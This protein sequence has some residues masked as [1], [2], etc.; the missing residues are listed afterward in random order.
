MGQDAGD[1]REPAVTVMAAIGIELS[2]DRRLCAVSLATMEDR[3]TPRVDIKEYISPDDAVLRVVR[4]ARYEPA[5]VGCFLDAQASGEMVDDLKG[6][7]AVFVRELN[8]AQA[9]LAVKTL[10]KA[11]RAVVPRVILGQHPGLEDAR[12][13][14]RW[15]RGQT[16]RLDLLAS[17][18]DQACLRADAF[19]FYGASH[20]ILP[21]AGHE[22]DGQGASVRDY[23]PG[24]ERM[25][26]RDEFL[27]SL[28]Y[29]THP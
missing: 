2:R 24:D 27:L 19:A 7:G 29:R 22:G 28:G 9:D 5:C 10:V 25:S 21:W 6:T 20:Q 11:V 3:K 1:G 23:R 18:A 17:G 26:D 12:K 14:A 15:T 16:R 8:T 4:L 13:D